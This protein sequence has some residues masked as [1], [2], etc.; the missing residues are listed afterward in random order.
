VNSLTSEIQQLPVKQ[1]A[2]G[3][4]LSPLGRQERFQSA[5]SLTG[6]EIIIRTIEIEDDHES[7]EKL[8]SRDTASV[9]TA[10]IQGGRRP[11]NG[12]TLQIRDSRQQRRQQEVE[13]ASEQIN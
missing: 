13:L 1:E 6:A 12:Q 5:G 11:P 9:L 10:P 2:A 4:L 7:N 3:T 8:T